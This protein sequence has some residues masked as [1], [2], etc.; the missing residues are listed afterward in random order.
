MSDNDVDV[1]DGAW[2][3]FVHWR[4]PIPYLREAGAK[5]H[6]NWR[7]YI[8]YGLLIA[9]IILELYTATIPILLA[10][11]QDDTP[12]IVYT[13]TGW[14]RV[15]F[16]LFVCFILEPV[17]F[18][19]QLVKM[20]VVMVT[21]LGSVLS[22]GFFVLSLEE[23]AKGIKIA[24]VVNYVFLVL[25]LSAEIRLMV[26][27]FPWNKW[28]IWIYKLVR[29]Y[30]VLFFIAIELTQQYQSAILK[31]SHKT[32]DDPSNG[33]ELTFLITTLG[34]VVQLFVLVFG[35]EVGLHKAERD[36]RKARE[37]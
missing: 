3:S 10:E 19:L 30:H 12:W 17:R 20:D 25:T 8:A 35:R 37:L 16:F 36:A 6:T 28:S 14:P 4:G 32:V 26:K 23:G 29:A 7:I 13:A 21:G 15:M 34:W 33:L 27:Y 1:H 24:A 18:V 2:E 11:D 31:A 22:Y 5:G 9:V